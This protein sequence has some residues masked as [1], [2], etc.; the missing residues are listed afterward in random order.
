[1]ARNA[2]KMTGAYL[3]LFISFLTIILT[4]EVQLLS[5]L[6]GIF[7]VGVS[8]I[9]AILMWRDTTDSSLEVGEKIVK[10]AKTDR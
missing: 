5:P 6:G 8:C 4:W 1:M 7:I 2:M 9:G 3:L 10:R